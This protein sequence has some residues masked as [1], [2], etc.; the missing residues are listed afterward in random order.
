M[1]FAA[2]GSGLLPS[3]APAFFILH[4][5]SIT[6]LAPTPLYYTDVIRFWTTS[7]RSCPNFLPSRESLRYIPLS[8]NIFLKDKGIE[9]SSSWSRT[10]YQSLH[11]LIQGSS[12]VDFSMSCPVDVSQPTHRQ[13]S[14]DVTKIKKKISISDLPS[15]LEPRLADFTNSLVFTIEIIWPDKGKRLQVAILTR[16]SIYLFALSYVFSQFKVNFPSHHIGPLIKDSLRWSPVW[17]APYR[18]P[19]CKKD[20]DITW[21]LLHLCLASPHLSNKMNPQSPPTCPFCQEQGTLLHMFLFCK[22]LESLKKDLQKIFHRISPALFLDIELFLF[23]L[24]PSQGSFS[25]HDNAMIDFILTLCKATIY[26]TYMKQ[27]FSYL[28]TWRGCERSE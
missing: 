12:W 21:R 11:D 25:N 3:L 10:P 19:S 5:S 20:G 4:M 24:F 7:A 13:I 27:G 17:K 22:S 23:H 8:P 1:Y 15:S 6:P 18:F 26:Q 9:L 28:T 2:C 16:T 14:L